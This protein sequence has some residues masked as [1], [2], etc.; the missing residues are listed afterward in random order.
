MS[1]PTEYAKPEDERAP[2][3]MWA[4]WDDEAGIVT[5]PVP[6]ETE[7]SADLGHLLAV[8]W[9]SHT[10]VPANTRLRMI[11]IHD[12]GTTRTEDPAD[13]CPVCGTTSRPKHSLTTLGDMYGT[14]VCGECGC[15]WPCAEAS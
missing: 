15:S 3:I 2:V 11:H 1:D 8:A 5:E 12:D 13:D 6:T 7:A 4:A 14:E 10:I 9:R